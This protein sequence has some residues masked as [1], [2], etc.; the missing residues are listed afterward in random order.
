MEQNWEEALTKLKVGSSGGRPAVHKPLLVLLLVARARAGKPNRVSFREIAEP[1]EKLIA[2]H[3]PPVKKPNAALP[4]W[5]LQSDGF[6]KVMERDELAGTEGKLG[7]KSLAKHDV[8]GE[9][10]A[11][12]WAALQKDAKLAQRVTAK[13]LERYWPA[14]E[15]AKVERELGARG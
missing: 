9:F 1:L 12:A 13:I 5:H 4:F 11:K 8:V 7:R 3:G 6:W 14:G 10:D 2:T 15:R